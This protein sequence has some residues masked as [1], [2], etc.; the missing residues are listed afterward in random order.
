MM[1]ILG[2]NLGVNSAKNP[3]LL[4][5]Q[6]CLSRRHWQTCWL[7]HFQI[8][9]RAILGT[10]LL[11]A[12]GKQPAHWYW[13]GSF[14]LKVQKECSYPLKEI[15]CLWKACWNTKLVCRSFVPFQIT[16]IRRFYLQ[17]FNSELSSLFSGSYWRY[18]LGFDRAW[19]LT[20]SCA[21]AVL[22]TDKLFLLGNFLEIF[23]Y[24]CNSVSAVCNAV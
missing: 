7:D 19:F 21:V 22:K 13:H 15:L 10:S 6:S 24:N 17:I 9:S 11:Y 8:F 1:L 3:I 23:I 20:A 18:W 12:Y 4:N 5:H 2:S 16:E 14:P